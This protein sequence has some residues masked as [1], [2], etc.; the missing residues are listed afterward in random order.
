MKGVVTAHAD[1]HIIS[2]RVMLRNSCPLDVFGESD[3]LGDDVVFRCVGVSTDVA[4]LRDWGP[5][6]REIDIFRSHTLYYRLEDRDR[7]GQGQG[8]G[9]RV[10][11]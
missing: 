10:E 2:L 11:G 4:E 7:Q 3:A 5:L 1:V 9:P 8:Q 6:L